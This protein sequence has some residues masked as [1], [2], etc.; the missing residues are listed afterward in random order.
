MTGALALEQNGA[1]ALSLHSEFWNQLGVSL[2]PSSEDQTVWFQCEL[3]EG[4]KLY[5]YQ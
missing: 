2:L 1:G 4:R 3:M 5:L